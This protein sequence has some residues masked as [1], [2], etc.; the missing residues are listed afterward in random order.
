MKVKSLKT[1][2]EIS[3]KKYKISSL[4]KNE[5]P[6]DFLYQSSNSLY[7]PVISVEDFK[8]FRDAEN[9]RWSFKRN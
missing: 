9:T 2:D 6:Q 4:R 5:D 3:G 1:W 8:R 7:T